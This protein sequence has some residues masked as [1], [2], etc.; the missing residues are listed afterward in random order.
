[1]DNN[2]I[3]VVEDFLKKEKINFSI[4]KENSSDFWLDDIN[5][6][7]T[8]RFKIN[9]PKHEIFYDVYAP[10]YSVHLKEETIKDVERLEFLAEENRRWKLAESI[11]DIWLVLDQIKFWARKNNFS[12]TEKQLL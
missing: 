7:I 10:E 11:E 6:A 9:A 2:L 5:R 8:I 3:P 1:M 4:F 12:V